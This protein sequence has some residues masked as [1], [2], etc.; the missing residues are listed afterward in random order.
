MGHRNSFRV[1]KTGADDRG[2]QTIFATDQYFLSQKMLF[3]D[4]EIAQITN[5]GGGGGVLT[6]CSLLWIRGC[7]AR[8]ELERDWN[9]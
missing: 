7:I 5:W 3:S 8:T 2:V 6:H 1:H 9:S 4:N